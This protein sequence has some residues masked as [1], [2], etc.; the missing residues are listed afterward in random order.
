M[1]AIPDRKEA[2]ARDSIVYKL[3]EILADTRIADPDE[4][5]CAYREGYFTQCGIVGLY[6][7]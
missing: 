6:S 3:S 4:R 2:H 5:I 7:E 1:R